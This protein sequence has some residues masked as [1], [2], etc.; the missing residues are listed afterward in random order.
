MSG[1]LAIDAGHGLCSRRAGVYDPGAVG[2][3][4][5][6]ATI[7]LEWALTLKHVL[8]QA[9]QAVILTR[10][11]AEECAPLGQ[12][13]A[14][15]QA[16]GATRL[17]SL[18]CN[19]N[20]GTPGTGT[21]VLFPGG[22]SQAFARLVLNAAVASLGLPNRG[23]KERSNLAILKFNGPCC[24]LELGFINHPGDAALL[25]QRDVRIRFAEHLLRALSA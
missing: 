4:L 25:A 5:Q 9:G 8:Q 20:A 22:Q 11:T 21:E 10:N 2:Q 1:L 18:H 12:R 15:M 3:G 7:T 23:I 13:V 16:A 19:A 17:L 14:R 6:E 24:L